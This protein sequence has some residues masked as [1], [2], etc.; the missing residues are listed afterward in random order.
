MRIALADH[1]DEFRPFIEAAMPLAEVT[2]VRIDLTASYFPDGTR[3]AGGGYSAPVPDHH[4]KWRGK[5]ADYD[6]GFLPWAWPGEPG[7][8][9]RQ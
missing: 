6:P 5:G 7:W 3:F 1:L 4:G 8:P 9:E 2:T